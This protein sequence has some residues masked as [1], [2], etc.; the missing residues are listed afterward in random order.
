MKETIE[1]AVS[2]A[3]GLAVIGKEQV[4]K[5]VGQLVEKGE[6]TK[7]ESK[8]WIDAAI[9]KGKEM[10]STVEKAAQQKLQAILKEHN[11]VTKEEL[12]GL[13]KRIEVLEQNQSK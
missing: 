4:D 8:V 10:E 7:E 11:L 12:E 2:L 6:L 3:F 5:V 13:I 1:K 9:A